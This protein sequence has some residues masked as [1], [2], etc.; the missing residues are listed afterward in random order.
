MRQSTY[1][2]AE[3]ADLDEFKRK[4]TRKGGLDLIP[5]RDR[6]VARLSNGTTVYWHHPKR[7]T[8]TVNGVSMVI[9]P[10]VPDNHFG[11]E[12]DGKLVIFNAEELMKHLRWA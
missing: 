4:E 12:I 10:K 11:I 1:S 8:E 9:N 3:V 2:Q 5:V 7:E 6:G